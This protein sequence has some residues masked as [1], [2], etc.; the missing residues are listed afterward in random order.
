LAS[1][2]WLGALVAVTCLLHASSA[3]AGGAPHVHDGVFFKGGLAFGALRTRYDATVNTPTR[4]RGTLIGRDVAFE[5]S[6]GGTPLPGLVIA[7]T[8]VSHSHLQEH[9]DNASI[10]QG[11]DSVSNLWMMFGPLVRYYP[12]PSGG[13]H[14]DALIALAFHR[15]TSERTVTEVPLLCPLLFPACLDIKTRTIT[16][17]EQTTG[18]GGALGAGYDFWVGRQWSLGLTLRL[19]VAHT[20]GRAGTYDDLSPTLGLALVF[21]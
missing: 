14:A 6:L 15:V 5:L 20:W 10:L 13:F 2:T 9:W 16:V 17:R 8:G 19:D 12:N 3:V 11:W 1:R 18:I 4:Q 21:Q 7:A